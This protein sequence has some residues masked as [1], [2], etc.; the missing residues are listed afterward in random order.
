MNRERIIRQYVEAYN[1]FHIAEMLENMDD[2][3]EF[4]NISNGNSTLHLYG[5]ENFR[6][7]AIM[8]KDYFLERKQE[9]MSFAHHPSHTEITIQYSAKLAMDVPEGPSK[10]T[11]LTLEGKSVFYFKEDKIIRLVDIS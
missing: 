9:I 8:A 2:A 3:V 11:V 7:Q 10:G 1:N 6:Q 4:E 5:K